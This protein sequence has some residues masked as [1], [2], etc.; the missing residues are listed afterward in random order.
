[1]QAILNLQRETAKAVQ[2]ADHC[3]ASSQAA[4]SSFDSAG[5][6][7]VE[8]QLLTQSNEVQVLRQASVQ[9]PEVSVRMC[10]SCCLASA[11]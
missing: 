7:E 9:L 6:I 10:S 3:M 4:Q 1:M 2:V 11:H 8:G 5:R